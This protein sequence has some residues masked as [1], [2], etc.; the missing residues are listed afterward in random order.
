MTVRDAIPSSWTDYIKSG[1]LG[2]GL[3]LGTTDKV[4]S[5]PTVIDV[6]EDYG[7]LLQERLIFSF[8][9]RDEEVTEAVLDAIFSD[10]RN[11]GKRSRALAID[12]TNE[13]FFAQ[14]LAKRLRKHCAVYLVKGSENLTHAGETMTAKQLLGHLFANEHIDGRIAT[15]SG[16][17]VKDDRRLVKKVKGLFNADTDALGQHGDTWDAG[18]LA[19]WA[20]KSAG[21]VEAGG[22]AVSSK[23][24][25]PQRRGLL[26]P[27]AHLFRKLTRH[28]NA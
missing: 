19:R 17:W 7:G 3:D 14:K 13:T 25:K 11:A 2:I 28:S 18:K 9:T 16:P 22:I 23:S 12:A 15:P 27:F 6:M 21:R 20:L 24:G 10:L 4:T 8:K 5:N 1:A 26:R